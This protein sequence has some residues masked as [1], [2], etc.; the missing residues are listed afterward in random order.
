MSG[1][2]TAP[3]FLRGD[4]RV[5]FRADHFS[6]G[7]VLY[8]I[9]TD[10]IPY[11]GHGGKVG[12]LPDPIRS[13]SRL[14]PA[15]EL[16]PERDKISG[17]IWQPIDKLLSRSLAIEADQRFDTTS[18]WLD[19]WNAIMAEL[20]KVDSGRKSTSVAVRLLDWLTSRFG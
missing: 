11:D 9:L 5:D 20:R 14:I 4:R 1:V 18:E 2:Y 3:E 19:G 16:S 12:V 8:E 7:V 10:K 17:R 6:L 13:G 15:S